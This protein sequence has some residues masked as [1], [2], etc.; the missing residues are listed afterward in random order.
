MT[1]NNKMEIKMETI[2]KIKT[3][4]VRTIKNNMTTMK[5]IKMTKIK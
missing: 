2:L 1:T 4:L 3:I 5:K